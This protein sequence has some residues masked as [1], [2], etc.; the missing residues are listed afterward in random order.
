MQNV[1]TL[2]TVLAL[3][4][5]EAGAGSKHAWQQLSYSIGAVSYLVIQAYEAVAPS[6]QN[7]FRSQPNSLITTRAN[8]AFLHIPATQFLCKLQD[9][10]T[11]A[12]PGKLV[13]SER[14]WLV[15]RRVAGSPALRERLAEAIKKLN[16]AVRGKK[17]ITE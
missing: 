6:R 12:A 8:R 7:S 11:F 16:A 5:K 1:D 2:I 15:F 3:Y 10:P 4:S 17:G 13:L 9:P 14:D